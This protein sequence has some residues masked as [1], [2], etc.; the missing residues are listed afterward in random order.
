MYVAYI[1]A[2]CK[3]ICDKHE[4]NGTDVSIDN[5]LWTSY[6]FQTQNKRSEDLE[7][8]KSGK[9]LKERR[10]VLEKERERN[11]HL[12]IL[13]LMYV[14]EA[15]E[16]LVWASFV[17]INAS[18][19]TVGVTKPK[20][21][22]RSKFPISRK[23]EIDF[24][25][26]V[27]WALNTYCMVGFFMQHRCFHSSFKLCSGRLWCVAVLNYIHSIRIFLF[28]FMRNFYRISLT[29]PNW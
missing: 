5:V 6:E 13:C 18:R 28:F 17:L 27:H 10:K 19:T 24:R 26:R 2:T 8:T 29:E 16:I 25:M 12:L 15:K 1:L 23:N 20:I 3:Y 4:R 11:T 22:I 9:Y 21:R 14:F 7:S